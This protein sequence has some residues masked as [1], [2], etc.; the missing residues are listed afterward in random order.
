M[1]L[2]Q[3]TIWLLIVIILS[4]ACLFRVI[5]G[6]VY[7]PIMYGKADFT[8]LYVAADFALDNQSV[9]ANEA[10]YN[11]IT[12]LREAKGA[13][14]YLYPPTALLLFIPMQVLPFTAAV[15]LWLTISIGL[16]IT[17][18]YL[19]SRLLIKRWSAQDWAIIAGGVLLFA[20]LYTTLRSGQVNILLTFLF[21]L[22]LFLFRKKYY[23]WTGCVLAIMTLIKLFPVVLILYY[24]LKKQFSV[25]GYA[26]I[27][28]ILLLGISIGIFGM[29]PHVIYLQK[30]PERAFEGIHTEGIT[31]HNNMT[32][33]AVIQ[34]MYL[35]NDNT[36]PFVQENFADAKQAIHQFTIRI[37]KTKVYISEANILQSKIIHYSI[38]IPLL[39]ALVII[40]WRPVSSTSETLLLEQS[41]WLSFVLFAAKD[42][43]SEYLI[44]LLPVIITLLLQ[45]NKYRTIVM[46]IIAVLAISEMLLLPYILAPDVLYVLPLSFLGNVLLLSLLT[47]LVVK[48]LKSKRVEFE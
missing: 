43:H 45:P 18:V 13:V 1:M 16:V 9:Y 17:T 20:P 27:S 44:F 29:Q 47:W 40:T 35:L 28:G 25:V 23:I 3:R 38:I 8:V 11:R 12:E 4:T 34:R 42:A 7:E 10:M 6:Y 41:W 26:I 2:K 5:T 39:L 31:R 24:L 14:R 37:E 22:Q 19:L 21:V 30:I 32:L 15:W 48:Q 46:S 36:N 33:N